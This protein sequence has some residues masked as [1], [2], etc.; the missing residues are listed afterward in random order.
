MQK[1]LLKVPDTKATTWYKE[2]S[3]MFPDDNPQPGVPRGLPALVML[4]VDS[5]VL[6]RLVL[7][8]AK[9]SKAKDDN[10]TR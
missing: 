4:A 10:R 7:P 3:K 2:L 5:V 1:I 6:D 9:V 8:K